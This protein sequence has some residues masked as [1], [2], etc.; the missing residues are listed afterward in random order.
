M[1]ATKDLRGFTT[2]GVV[3]G[4]WLAEAFSPRVFAC[5]NPWFNRTVPTGKSQDLRQV[6]HLSVANLEVHTT[7][8]KVDPP[9]PGLQHMTGDRSR[10][11]PCG[12]LLGCA[13]TLLDQ[14]VFLVLFIFILV[15][16]K[17]PSNSHYDNDT[18]YRSDVYFDG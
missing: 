11:V 13:I 18:L 2:L 16:G 5:R 10:K 7:I 3:L 15:K 4:S 8:C 12:L 9:Q 14:V 17:A 1:L 6:L